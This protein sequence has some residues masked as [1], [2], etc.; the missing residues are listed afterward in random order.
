[1][2]SNG[3]VGRVFLR[4]LSK[5][6][7]H[8]DVTAVDVKDKNIYPPFLVYAIRLAIAK[9]HFK[10]DAKLYMK[11]L[12]TLSVEIPVDRNGKFDL[13]RQK[14]EATKYEKLL[15]IKRTPKEFVREIED[16]F[17]TVE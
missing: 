1:M 7:F 6:T 2:N 10:Y 4:E 11:R 9:A 13:D 8:D 17:L 5:Y 3:N 14:I 15:E 16:K 12:K